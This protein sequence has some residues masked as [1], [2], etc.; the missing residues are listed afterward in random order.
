MMA[1]DIFLSHNS[2]DKS[3]VEYLA[4][5]LLGLLYDDDAMDL[6]AG[7]RSKRM[8]KTLGS[9]QSLWPISVITA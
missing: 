2:D 8:P 7:R 4:R 9:L 5:K 1:C 3:A 6:V